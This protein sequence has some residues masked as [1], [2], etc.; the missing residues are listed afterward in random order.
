MIHI[1]SG[2]VHSGKTTFLKNILYSLGKQ[3]LTIDGYFSEALWKKNEFLGYNLFDLKIHQSH[4]F[5]R[6]QGKDRWEKIGPFFFLPE[7]MDLAKKIIRRSQK[8]DLCVVDEVGPLELGGNGVWPALK[9]SLILRNLDFLL[10]VRDSILERF[11][12]KIHT[13]D[14][15]VYDI[16]EK[17]TPSRM[18]EYLLR[19]WEK[20]RKSE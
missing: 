20:R 13:N 6:K 8:A 19:N 2:P 17:I 7:T 4:P 3:N 1:L 10:V 5:I 12:G 16:E 14:V 11:M 9:D 15:V 18:A